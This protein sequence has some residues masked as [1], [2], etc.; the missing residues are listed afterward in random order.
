MG[1]EAHSVLSLITTASSLSFFGS[2]CQET[3]AG[4]ETWPQLLA[5]SYAVL[6]CA[7]QLS[8]SPQA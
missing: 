6:T 4:K 2:I 5:W 3:K 8:S 7:R 1:E